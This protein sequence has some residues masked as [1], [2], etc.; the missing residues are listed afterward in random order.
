MTGQGAYYV[1]HST[2]MGSLL[3]VHFH[4]AYSTLK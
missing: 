1:G 3:A 4:I 2:S